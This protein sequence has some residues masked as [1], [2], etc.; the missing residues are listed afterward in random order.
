M[1]S[2]INAIA[3]LLPALAQCKTS[4]QLCWGT[5]AQSNG[6]WYCSEVTAITYHNISSA[7]FYNKTTK[8]DPNTGL[9]THERVSYSATG[10][11]APFFGEVPC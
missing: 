11:D 7:G 10:T 9:C 8:I 5:A 3:I 6:N 4:G 1:L 2:T